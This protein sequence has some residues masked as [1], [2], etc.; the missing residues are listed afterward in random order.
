MSFLVDTGGR[1]IES[2]KVLKN[3]QM[4]EEMDWHLKTRL[5]PGNY[6]LIMIH[7]SSKIAECKLTI[8]L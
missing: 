5:T 2:K 4:E 3:V 1:V 7:G 6:Y 8:G